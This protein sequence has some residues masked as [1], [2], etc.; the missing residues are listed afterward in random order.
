MPNLIELKRHSEQ[1]DK[2]VLAL[3]ED[4]L[5]RAKDGTLRGVAVAIDLSEDCTAT[6]LAYANGSRVTALLGAVEL[7]KTKVIALCI[8]NTG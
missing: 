5:R 6:A 3:C 1:P 7:L 8:E 2:D 4:L